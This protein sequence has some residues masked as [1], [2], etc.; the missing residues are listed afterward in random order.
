MLITVR[1][2]NECQLIEGGRICQLADVNVLINI[3][4]TALSDNKGASILY[5]DTINVYMLFG[6]MD[7]TWVDDE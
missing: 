2:D 1:C 4:S 7:D 6:V 3:L 5:Q